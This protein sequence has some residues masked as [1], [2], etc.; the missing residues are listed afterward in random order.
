[1]AEW[2]TTDYKLASGHNNVAG[3]TAIT[4]ITDG[5]NTLQDALI[6]PNYSRGVRRNTL[7]SPKF[8]GTESTAILFSSLTVGLHKYLIDNYEGLVTI[9]LA[10]GSETFDDYN[11]TLVIPEYEPD[12]FYIDAN[13]T[14]AAFFQVLCPVIGISLV[15]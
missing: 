10:L 5:V 12:N 7:K 6:F 15:P 1:M 13:A 9:R 14:D 4:S 11:A 8:S 2:I 3:Y